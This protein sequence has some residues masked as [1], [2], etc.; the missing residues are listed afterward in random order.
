MH[1]EARSG[2][3]VWSFPSTLPLLLIHPVALKFLSLLGLSFPSCQT[4]L[5]DWTELKR[6]NWMNSQYH[7]YWGLLLS[8]SL[9]NLLWW[10]IFQ[11]NCIYWIRITLSILKLVKAMD[12]ANFELLL[13]M[14]LLCFH[15]ELIWSHI[16]KGKLLHVIVCILP[17]DESGYTFCRVVSRATL[18]SS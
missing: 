9:M 3:R 6:R 10:H 15:M 13:C 11:L 17:M 1:W 8:F 12:T 5:S 14:R 2:P 7:N 16:N 4:R 18:E